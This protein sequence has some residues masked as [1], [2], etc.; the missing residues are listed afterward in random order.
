ME[1]YSIRIPELRAVNLGKK[2]NPQNLGDYLTNLNY[3]KKLLK[4][5]A[6]QP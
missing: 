3:Y 1:K 6:Y 5:L 2:N 4:Y